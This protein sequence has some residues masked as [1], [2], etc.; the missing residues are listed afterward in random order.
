MIVVYLTIP[1]LCPKIKSILEGCRISEYQLL[2]TQSI[3]YILYTSKT[4][5]NE[6][7]F[8]MENLILKKVLDRVKQLK[9]CSVI[10]DETT[11]LST[12]SQLVTAV[13]R[14]FFQKWSI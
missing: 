11:D 3:I 14:Y 6:L 9:C 2:T 8:T 1:I 5:Q 10:F 12:V 4:T 13:I 7:I